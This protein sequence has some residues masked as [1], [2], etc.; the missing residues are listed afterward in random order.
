MMAPDAP[1]P[2]GV[3]AAADSSADAEPASASGNDPVSA[4]A[5]SLSGPHVCPRKRSRP[6]EGASGAGESS[7][8]SASGEDSE[9]ERGQDRP[10]A[11]GASIYDGFGRAP[12]HQVMRRSQDAS[13]LA[14]TVERPLRAPLLPRCRFR[15]PWSLCEQQRCSSLALTGQWRSENR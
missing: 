4:G 14:M 8:A 3:W 12:A 6:K 10:K 5:T 15:S 9:D 11:G 7:E 1:L 13:I 2:P